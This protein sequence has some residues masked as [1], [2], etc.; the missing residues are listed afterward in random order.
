MSSPIGQSPCGRA[1]ATTIQRSTSAA[2]FQMTCTVTL[3]SALR[4]AVAGGCASGDEWCYT[5]R[6]TASRHPTSARVL[7]I[8][9]T[10]L[11][12]TLAT[13]G[14]ELPPG[15]ALSVVGALPDATTIMDATSGADA[16]AD[17][18]DAGIVDAPPAEAPPATDGSAPSD[19]STSPDVLPGAQGY[20]IVVMP[21]TQY[22]ASSW[23]DIFSAQ[24]R[25]VVENRDAQR[26]AFVLQTGDIVDTDISAQWEVAARSLHLLDGQVPYVIAAGNHDY[27]NLADRMGMGNAYFPT[28]GFT[29]FSWFGGTFEPEHIENSFSLIPAGAVTWLVLSLEFGPRDEV[30]TWAD[31]ILKRFPDRPAIVITHAYLHHGGN[32][33]DHHGVRQDYNPH[34]YVMMGQPG[35]SINDGEELWQKLILPN[36][37]VKLVLSGHDVSGGDLPPGTTGRL[38][39]ERPDGSRVH[40]LLAN[41]Q[42]CVAA[43]CEHSNQGSVVRGGSGYLRVLRFDPASSKIS[44]TT[45]SP[46]L[47]ASLVDPGNQF[48]LDAN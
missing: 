43:P 15:D 9:G 37:N 45:Y 48:E 42:T 41:Y 40:Q 27:A 33:Y 10:I 7:M 17:G 2:P 46:Y 25:W 8:G 3:P 47:D 5:S 39:S 13:L 24:T 44:V 4:C 30:V 21:D 12:A 1:P 32:R 23:P 35:T 34:D 18:V 31:A 36:S 6:V 19:A 26:I 38:T 20:A 16:A 11:A 22:Y 28:S 14:C 29:P